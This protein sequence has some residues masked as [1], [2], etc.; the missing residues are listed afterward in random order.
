MAWRQ[1]P[2]GGMNA[3]QQRAVTTDMGKGSSSTMTNSGVG[4]PSVT[5]IFRKGPLADDAFWAA[6]GKG[7][8][9]RRA[10]L[11]RK[12]AE[13]LSSPHLSMRR[14]WFLALL[15]N[16]RSGDLAAVHAGMI[17]QEML[18]GRFNKEYE[19]M[20]ERASEVD[21]ALVLGKIKKE[22]GGPGRSTFS[23]QAK[24]MAS[25]SGVDADKATAWWNDLPDGHLRDFLA[26]PLIEGLARENPDKAWQAAQMFDPAK[27]ADFAARLVVAFAKDK[28]PEAGVA[29]VA[30]S[31]G[32]RDKVEGT[33]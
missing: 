3:G 11:Q 8:E 4:A 23:W 15:E 20:M 1:V 12:T 14:R 33:V 24:C 2:I 7:P 32:R 28:G 5:Q 27:R 21:G 30:G 26:T 13:I 17:E 9:E 19:E 6:M 10:A 29:W 16:Y 18:G 22:S 31:G 25:W